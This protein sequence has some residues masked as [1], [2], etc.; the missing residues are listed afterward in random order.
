MVSR[1]RKLL[2]LEISED[3][4]LLASAHPLLVLC[5]VA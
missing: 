4:V 2:S 5:S 1:V 3:V